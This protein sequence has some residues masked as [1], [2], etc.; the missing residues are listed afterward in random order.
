MNW[1]HL[2]IGLA[3]LQFFIFCMAVGRA[4][5][6]YKVP[7]PATTGNEVF[8][9][10]FRVQMNTLEQLIIFVPS[11]LMF[12]HYLNP[13]WAAALGAVY[14]IGRIMYFR[15]YVKAPGSRSWGFAVSSFPNLALLAGGII[16]AVIALVRHA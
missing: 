13:C 14:L 8:E 3:L 15:A 6:T 5:E 16:G 2:V 12:A 7:A 1:V 9:R 10:Y 11:I 4:R